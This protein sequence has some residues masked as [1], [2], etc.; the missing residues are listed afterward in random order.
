MRRRQRDQ[1]C[2][3]PDSNNNGVNVVMV[4]A[5]CASL[6]YSS[7]TIVRELN[8]NGCAEAHALSQDGLNWS[9]DYQ[10]SSGF[11]AEYLC[12]QN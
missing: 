10:G 6:G 5:L 1:I 7:G 9:S 12:E 3:S 11:G 4:D 2:N 8:S